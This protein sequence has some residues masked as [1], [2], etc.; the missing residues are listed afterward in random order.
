MCK[1]FFERFAARFFLEFIIL[2]ISLQFLDKKSS[3]L[4]KH[5]PLLNITGQVSIGILNSGQKY[6]VVIASVVEALLF[7]SCMICTAPPIL[8]LLK[9]SSELLFCVAHISFKQF[10][11]L[12]LN[13]N[14][15]LFRLNCD[16]YGSGHMST[17]MMQYIE[18]V[19]VF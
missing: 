6:L 18:R 5:F 4:V 15:V 3:N 10:F 8:L 11:L 7:L 1:P 16:W 2:A 12:F 17:S 14:N 13:V 19:L 9:L